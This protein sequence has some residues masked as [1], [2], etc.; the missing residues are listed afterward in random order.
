M[1]LLRRAAELRDMDFM[2]LTA[3]ADV[4]LKLGLRDQ[5]VSAAKQSMTRLESALAKQPDNAT[6]LAWGATILAVLDEFARA[7][8]W[9]KRA[10]ALSPNNFGVRVLVT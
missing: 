10:V 3:L 7:D 9:A 5:S 6:L 1:P 8:E 4:C 2:A